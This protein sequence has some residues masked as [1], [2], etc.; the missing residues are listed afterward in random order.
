[1]NSR[2]RK[3]MS[4]LQHEEGMAMIEALP[5]L[6]I[7][8]VLLGFG[9]GLF[10]VVHTAILNSIGARTYAI[11]TLSNRADVTMF[12]D[13]KSNGF[14]HF[15]RIGNRFHVI[16]SDKVVDQLQ[17]SSEAPQYATD[18]N[19]AFGLR[20]TLALTAEGTQTDHNI[21]VDN[22]VGRN[23]KNSGVSVSPAWVMV[24]YGICVNARCGGD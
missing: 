21:N 3:I 8:V 23:R 15:D 14:T 6:V 4:R 13:R 20:T 5:I 18:R 19:I 10:G 24:G 11:E 2:Q 1:M 12:R 9:L 7:F 16:D 22:I 17:Q